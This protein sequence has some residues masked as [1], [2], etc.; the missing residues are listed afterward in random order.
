MTL[1]KGNGL[2]L[3]FLA[4]LSFWDWDWVLL[5]WIPKYLFTSSILLDARDHFCSLAQGCLF[6][7][8]VKWL[9]HRS[10][11][12]PPTV[13]SLYVP[14]TREPWEWYLSNTTLCHA[15]LKCIHSSPLPTRYSRKPSWAALFFTWEACHPPLLHTPIITTCLSYQELPLCL[16]HLCLVLIIHLWF[17]SHASPFWLLPLISTLP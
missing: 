12:T 17:I 1:I 4:A 7:G 3:I 16:K 10:P 5:I 13:L 2:L 14:T 11:P 15:W 8:L 9:P 6:P